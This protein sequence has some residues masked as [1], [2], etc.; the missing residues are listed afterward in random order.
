MKRLGNE[1]LTIS[2]FFI[3]A[4]LHSMNLL[5]N[6]QIVSTA[7][8]KMIL[9]LILHHHSCHLVI[10]PIYVS[11]TNTEGKR[12][13]NVYIKYILWTRQVSFTKFLSML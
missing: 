5:G 2:L 13:Y 1:K 9:H 7:I 6:I 8:P 12:S 11:L 4:D 10:T 3:F